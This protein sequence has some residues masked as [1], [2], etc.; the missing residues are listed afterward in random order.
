MFKIVWGKTIA[1]SSIQHAGMVRAVEGDERALIRCVFLALLMTV[2]TTIMADDAS[3]S[4]RI[5]FDIP[6]QRADLA[7]TQFA[8]QADLTLIFPFDEVRER[9]A[10]RLVGEYLVEEAVEMLLAGT[11]LKPTFRDRA[12]LN[13]AAV[14]QPEP[15]GEEMTLN[16]KVGLGTFLAAIFSVGAGA[17]EA[18]DGVGVLEEIIV[19]AQKREQSLQDV[20]VSIAVFDAELMDRFNVTDFSDFADMVPGLSYA[21]TGAV[22][23]SNYFIRGIGQ[24]GQGLSPTTAVYLD[25]TPLQTHTL[26]GSSQPDPKLVDVARIEV[27]RGPQGVLFGSSALGGTVRIITNQPDASQYEGM[28]SGSVSNI[29]DGDQSWDVRGM[30]N[31]PLVDDT[32]ALRLV[33]T[34][35]FD[36]GW[37]DNLKP[38]GADVFEN[39]NNPTAIDEDANS[40]N[41]HMVRAA[42]SY[43][44]DETWTITGSI[45]SQETEQDV[46]ANHSDLTFGIESRLRARWHESFIEEEFVIGNL[47][48]TK[49]LDAFGGMSILSSTSWLDHEFERQFDNTAF[50]S[51][52]IEGL[53][54]P[55]PNGEFYWS[56]SNREFTTEQF[57]QEIRAVSTSDSAWQ[58]VVGVYYN[59]IEQHARSFGPALNLY[60]ATAPPPFGASDPPLLGETFSD[61]EEDEIA[62]FGELSYSF[63]DNWMLSVG[64]RYF[65]Y[66][67]TDTQAS[68]GLGG[69]AGGDLRFQFSEG[70]EEDGFTPR[71]VLAYQATDNVNLYGSYA[72]GFRTGGVNSPII[73][74]SCTD[75]ELDDAGI[76]KLPPPFTSDET[77]TFEIGAKTT[78]LDGRATLNVAVYTID[79]KDFQQTATITCGPQ[80]QFVESF[81]ANAG[82]IESDGFEVEFSML[83][84]DDFLVAGGVA[85]TDAIYVEGFT[86]LG[87]PAGSSLLDVPEL[88][89]NIR[90]EYAFQISQFWDGHAMLAANYVDDT[91]TGFGEGEPEPRPDYT[92]VDFLVSFVKEAVTVTLFI[93]NIF[94]ETQVYGQEFAQSPV[95]TTATSFFAAHTGQPRTTGVRVR[96]DF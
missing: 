54:G 8:E 93:D 19:T 3:K 17:Q 56:G 66:D 41:Y 82:A 60:G 4:E 15:E 65:D 71:V 39:I 5:L 64:G 81:T 38:V 26:Q 30:V 43:T 28:V 90:G 24:V 70:N 86:T 92:V 52:Q 20:P 53:V 61:F 46:E 51:G 7:L 23:N 12:V 75:Q 49:E 25:E 50:R 76:P 74:S 33:G 35:G 63:A 87:L 89:W 55:S 72:N 11:G 59:T 79:W 68:Y 95:S 96:W 73:N 88:T 2:S 80:E 6:Q 83:F 69:R 91:I 22:G 21:T 16:K 29:T 77:D 13:I 58:Y 40:V 27:L 32:L 85:N 62:V 78:W 44:P 9:T 57:T 48:I 34:R 94:D 84:S 10:N 36:G 1:H 14:N 45:L 18:A 37:I 67:Q 31:I 42:L 47:L